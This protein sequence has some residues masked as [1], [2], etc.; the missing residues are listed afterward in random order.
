[1]FSRIHIN[2]KHSRYGEFQDSVKEV[3]N[4]VH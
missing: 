4:V 3:L 2:Y 1:M